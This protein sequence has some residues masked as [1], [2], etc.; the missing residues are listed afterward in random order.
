MPKETFFNLPEE[1][2][3]RILTAAIDEFAANSFHN[4]GVN[5]I[6]DGAGIAKGSF[7]QYFEDKED[8]FRYLLEAIGEQKMAYLSG[9]MLGL[10]H[11]DFFQLLKELFSGGIQFAADHPKQ[12]LIGNRFVKDLD[13]VLKERILG[14][15]AP[16]SYM[17]LEQ[18]IQ[19]G[20]RKGELNAKLDI[21]FTA[22]FLTHISIAASE[23]YFIERSSEDY[24]AFMPYVEELIEIVRSGIQQR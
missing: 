17:F 6:V 12:A 22:F 1:K 5:R 10:G 7:Y 4:A 13:P 2:R 19:E 23:Y 24:Q 8:L 21:H 18:L 15:M 20:I 9:L 11:L 3:Q 14:D 16:K